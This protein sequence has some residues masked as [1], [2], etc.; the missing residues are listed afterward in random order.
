MRITRRAVLAGLATMPTAS[1]AE[2]TQR[3][4]SLNPCLDAALV[5]IADRAQVVA[6]SH[7]ARQTQASIL[8]ET[9]HD[10]PITYESAEEILAL[11][12]D[13]V[14]AS[15]HSAPA[16]RNALDRFGIRVE[17]FTVPDTVAQS[18]AQVERIATLT[19]NVSRGAA[20][21]ARIEAALRAAQP[22]DDAR[23][24]ALVFQPRG[25]AAGEGTL[26]DEMLKRTG[27]ANA[28]GRYGLK[29]WGNVPLEALLDDPPDILLSGDVA[30]DR[31]P[32]AERIVNHPALRLV[33]NRMRR[34]V[35][36]ERLLYCGGPVLLYTAPIL[37]AARKEWA[38][39]A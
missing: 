39:T 15:R 19:N 35:F 36:P 28:A 9:A 14:L 3:V 26:V 20:L 30:T 22:S 10:I 1:L 24:R 7:Y 13:L 21:I 32:W 5:E 6:I 17:T 37:A 8:A 33:A 11:R 29:K 16:T 12:P 18:I 27:F 38:R 4:V 34:G 25:F 23:P 31:P 2:P